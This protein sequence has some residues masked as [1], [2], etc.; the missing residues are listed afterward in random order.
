MTGISKKHQNFINEYLKTFNATQAYM[1]TYPKASYDTARANGS[2]LLAKANISS[3]IQNRLDEARMDAQEA[4]HRLSDIARG[5]IAEIMEVSS[6]GFN[7]DMQKANEA[8]LTKLIKRVKQKTTTYISNSENGEDREVH[9][10]DVE[11]YNAHE[12]IRDILKIT[13][14]FSEHVDITSKGEKIEFT[15]EERALRIAAILNE[16]KK[17]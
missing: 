12:A 11:L 3:E 2:A 1:R 16:K 4:L 17:K 9:E 14:K 8:G 7:L 10:I 13:G 6:V 5:D 15:D